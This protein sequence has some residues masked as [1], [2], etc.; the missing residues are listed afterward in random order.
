MCGKMETMCGMS[1]CGFSNS[2]GM[3]SGR[4][5]DYLGWLRIRWRPGRNLEWSG[6]QFVPWCH[7]GGSVGWGEVLVP[8]YRSGGGPMRCG[9]CRAIGLLKQAT[10]VLGWGSVHSRCW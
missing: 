8:V 9:S 3:G 2:R 4:L 1:A 7:D 10:K 6:S 5:R